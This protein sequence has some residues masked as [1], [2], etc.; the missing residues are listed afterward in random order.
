MVRN[1]VLVDYEN[2]QPSA[3]S[4]GALNDEWFVV[5]VFVGNSQNRLSYDFVEAFQRLQG[6][7]YIKISGN[8]KNALDFHIAYYLG[9]L[10][11]KEPKAYY[12]V[13]SQ[14]TGYEPLLTHLRGKAIRVNRVAAIEEIPLV[15]FRKEFSQMTTAQKRDAFLERLKSN[16]A[17][18]PGSAKTLRSSLVAFFQRQLP[19]EEVEVILQLLIKS[20][21]VSLADGKIT[22]AE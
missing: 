20:R 12:H 22:Y 18:R 5:F 11:V 9:E 4:L 6:G 17:S 1:Y 3:E 2:V 19:E 21:F 8:G 7:E 15:K 16:K 13:V 14:D 10:A